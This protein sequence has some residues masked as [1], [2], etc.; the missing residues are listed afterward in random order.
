MKLLLT[1]LLA[2]SAV[3]V[4][5]C[6]R[7]TSQDML[8]QCQ[9]AN[10]TKASTEMNPGK[11]KQF[12][13]ECKAFVDAQ[14]NLCA[15]ATE[16]ERLMRNNYEASLNEEALKGCKEICGGNFF[17]AKDVVDGISNMTDK[18]GSGVNTVIDSVNSTADSI[19]KKFSSSD[20]KNSAEIEEHSV[21]E[22]N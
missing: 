6:D 1:V 4:S 15:Y 9:K 18:I 7:N 8:I 3:L 5:G 19:S 12:Y 11:F 16:E 17:D 2:G 13:D 14:K 10:I 20:E 22:K 21:S